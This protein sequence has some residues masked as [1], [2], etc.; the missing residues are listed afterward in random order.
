MQKPPIQGIFFKTLLFYLF[1]INKNCIVK[2]NKMKRLLALLL[3]IGTIFISSGSYSFQD[4]GGGSSYGG[5]WD[6]TPREPNFNVT[7]TGTVSGGFVDIIGGALGVIWGLGEGVFT[8][9]WETLEDSAN[10]I[11][12]GIKDPLGDWEVETLSMSSNVD[13]IRAGM[14]IKFKRC[15]MQSEVLEDLINGKAFYANNEGVAG[16]RYMTHKTPGLNDYKR[17]IEAIKGKLAVIQEILDREEKIFFTESREKYTAEE[18]QRKENAIDEIV[19]K[20]DELVMGLGLNITHDYEIAK[21]YKREDNHFIQLVDKTLMK[22]KVAY[23]NQKSLLVQKIEGIE[24][25][26]EELKA[27]I[28]AHGDKRIC[29]D[30]L[31]TTTNIG[32]SK[33]FR[34]DTNNNEIDRVTFAKEQLKKA[35][36]EYNLRMNQ[37][38]WDFDPNYKKALQFDNQYKKI[39]KEEIKDEMDDIIDDAGG[40]GIDEKKEEIEKKT[41]EMYELYAKANNA[42]NITMQRYY[43]KKI[44]EARSEIQAL[45]RD[46]VTIVKLEQPESETYQRLIK[47]EEKTKAYMADT[48]FEDWA[49]D[50]KSQENDTLNYYRD[51]QEREL[52][53]RIEEA[54][55]LE[56]ETANEKL[57]SF[58]A[59][60][61]RAVGGKVEVDRSTIANPREIEKLEIKYREAIEAGSVIAA[62]E[63]KAR[64]DKMKEMR[65]NIYLPYMKKSGE[66]GFRRINVTS[67]QFAAWADLNNFGVEKYQANMVAG[68]EPGTIKYVYKK[69]NREKFEQKKKEALDA[70]LEMG[71]IKEEIDKLEEAKKKTGAI[72]NELLILRGKLNYLMKEYEKKIRE[73]KDSYEIVDT[74]SV[75]PEQLQMQIKRNTRSEAED[76]LSQAHR[77]MKRVKDGC[78]A[79]EFLACEVMYALQEQIKESKNII[80]DITGLRPFLQ[81]FYKKVQEENIGKDLGISKEQVRLDL[82]WFTMSDAAKRVSLADHF[83]I[84]D[85]DRQTQLIQDI[86]KNLKESGK[87]TLEVYSISTYHKL[88]SEIL[89]EK[90]KEHIKENPQEFNEIMAVAANID[91]KGDIRFNS[92]F[93]RI[94]QED[95]HALVT[96]EE[97]VKK[98]QIKA[99]YESGEAPWAFQMCVDGLVTV[100]ETF[101]ISYDLAKPFVDGLHAAG[102]LSDEGMQVLFTVAPELD[103]SQVIRVLRGRG[104]DTEGWRGWLDTAMGGADLAAEVL[105]LGAT[106]VKSVAFS[107]AQGQAKMMSMQNSITRM[108]KLQRA[109]AWSMDEIFS[110]MPTGLGDFLSTTKQMTIKAVNTKVKPL[111]DNIFYKA[112][113]NGELDEWAKKVEIVY[114]GSTVKVMNWNKVDDYDKFV[115]IKSNDNL[116]KKFNQGLKEIEDSITIGGMMPNSYYR[117]AIRFGSKNFL[118]GGKALQMIHSKEIMRH[119]VKKSA[120]GKKL[121]GLEWANV[122]DDMGRLVTDSLLPEHI[123]NKQPLFTRQWDAK[124]NIFNY[125][126]IDYGV[127]NDIEKLISL[128]NYNLSHYFDQGMIDHIKNTNRD[129]ANDKTILA[130]N[131]GKSTF[132]DLELEKQ[133]ELVEVYTGVKLTDAEKKLIDYAHINVLRQRAY[134]NA[135]IFEKAILN[136]VSSVDEFRRILKNNLKFKEN[137]DN[138]KYV[139]DQTTGS[140]YHVAD[141]SENVLVIGQDI[142]QMVAYDKEQGT[143][144]HLDKGTNQV[145]YNNLE[146][147]D[148][149][150]EKMRKTFENAK[151]EE[152]FKKVQNASEIIKETEIG[153]HFAKVNYG[154]KESLADGVYKEFYSVNEDWTKRL[155]VAKGRFD[156]G[157]EQYIEIMGFLN[158]FDNGAV[159]FASTGYIPKKRLQALNEGLDSI[160]RKYSPFSRGDW[161]IKLP[162][163]K[164]YEED[165]LLFFPVDDMPNYN[166]ETRMLLEN[167]FRKQSEDFIQSMKD[168]VDEMYKSYGARAKAVGEW[169][170]MW[171][172]MNAD[173]KLNDYWDMKNFVK[174]TE[175]VLERYLTFGPEAINWVYYNEKLT[176]IAK[177]SFPEY[178]GAVK[179]EVKP[180]SRMEV[181]IQEL[182]KAKQDI[183]I[184]L[185]GEPGQVEAYVETIDKI[186]STNTGFKKVTGESGRDVWVRETVDELG[187]ITKEVY[188][189]GVENSSYI[190]KEVNTP[191]TVKG[192]ADLRQAYYHQLDIYAL[193]VGETMGKIN[194]DLKALRLSDRQFKNIEEQLLKNEANQ[195]IMD[196]FMRL[197]DGVAKGQNMESQIYQF[198]GMLDFLGIHQDY[199]FKPKADIELLL[200]R[201]KWFEYN[202]NKVVTSGGL[203]FQDAELFL[204]NIWTEF[205]MKTGYK[206]SVDSTGNVQWI[207]EQVLHKKPTVYLKE[208]LNEV[209]PGVSAEIL[210]RA[211]RITG[212]KYNEI[213]PKIAKENPL[214]DQDALERMAL[215]EFS[216]AINKKIETVT[217]L[218][219]D[220]YKIVVMRDTITMT[221][222]GR[223][224]LRSFVNRPET[225]EGFKQWAEAV[226]NQ[227][228]Q[229]K[230]ESWVERLKRNPQEMYLGSLEFDP[231]GVIEYIKHTSPTDDVAKHRIKEFAM[232]MG[233]L[234]PA[235]KVISDLQGGFMRNPYHT[236]KDS[237]AAK[238]SWYV[239]TS[240]L[241]SFDLFLYNTAENFVLRGVERLN[242]EV[243][244]LV[245]KTFNK[246][247]SQITEAKA[248]SVPRFVGVDRTYAGYKKIFSGKGDP[249]LKY[250]DF[251]NPAFSENARFLP[252]LDKLASGA[253]SDDPFVMTQY[254]KEVYRTRTGYKTA[255]SLT[256]VEKRLSAIME[257]LDI[258]DQMQLEEV[259]DDMRKYI[260]GETV[261]PP[262]WVG[263]LNKDQ[264]SEILELAEKVQGH[265]ST[266]A[267]KKTIQQDN[268][269]TRISSKIQ[270]GLNIMTTGR[271]DIGLGTL[272]HTFTKVPVNSAIKVFEYSGVLSALRIP[273]ILYNLKR[274]FKGLVSEM[275][276]LDKLALKQKVIHEISKSIVGLSFLGGGIILYDLNLITI[277]PDFKG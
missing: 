121:L 44:R 181:I 272:Y 258:K 124:N 59:D 197:K 24:K 259:M 72:P 214:L 257:A 5:W 133:L 128:D 30:I 96:S 138:T 244:N 16:G 175:E 36:A 66:S 260:Q 163:Y 49:Q 143:L 79:G 92:T 201:A 273:K 246:K 205:S 265:C 82:K 126:Q 230:G 115:A 85:K 88:K 34:F 31:E 119:F 52:S 68:N 191:A 100:A 117:E 229:F 17:N 156:E 29:D 129:I 60:N 114:D 207:K 103:Q 14:N 91:N 137:I 221:P 223:K 140:I 240:K 89:Q 144:I 109:A 132:F 235:K 232:E 6:N 194:D 198:N 67:E 268:V 255:T 108:G 241:A 187:N 81:K 9:D 76:R 202:V 277:D 123:M 237:V 238:A 152:V 251:K 4:F 267:L 210:E 226:Q 10:A 224:I 227:A 169:E 164:K 262:K 8:G 58:L 22:A 69:F 219:K 25:R 167:N 179:W 90:I 155:E 168:K 110:L 215:G 154:I 209:K 98:E 104:R 153:R 204:Q 64:L 256:Q 56:G 218:G 120:Y 222:K 166:R 195:D 23:Q 113:K 71:R 50:F 47:T 213:Y 247:F 271:T 162:E 220:D 2:E 12:D 180:V 95:I 231:E 189:A 54:G 145:S 254:A 196:S 253:V 26:I 176:D 249:S 182:K 134:E 171:K 28:K 73:A 172:I 239:Y 228:E 57:S 146:L 185:S 93:N 63:F 135:V 105:F 173:G 269:L 78:N 11:L 178:P 263:A 43:E 131:K 75:T 32:I 261:Q 161:E 40:N 266:I 203:P 150:L 151:L 199:A 264:V 70:F 147:T 39:I 208:L 136:N 217:A 27:E 165:N 234:K 184:T 86:T 250:V 225:L 46:I 33:T 188:D 83:G 51:L 19:K 106:A 45:K 190:V 127:V 125:S 41:S 216:E 99:W 101:P 170:D 7:V 18:I 3:M 80:R 192:W 139:Y 97:D 94:L 211:E 157:A 270:Q 20:T 193:H 242:E 148:D 1:G 252:F 130:Y 21:E 53:M 274:N 233:R 200:D 122:Y 174:D 13:G 62:N 35:I 158:E 149:L 159:E 212:L 116:M 55:K 74:R 177:N 276:H 275:D 42:D 15:Y 84:T 38:G 77:E 87:E 65:V 61:V 48:T 141:Q 102:V 112:L 248:A 118:D 243:A 183:A 186:F 160:K 107:G 206:K 142:N 37:T 245:E 111:M 236:L